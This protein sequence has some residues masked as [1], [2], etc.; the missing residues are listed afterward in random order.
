MDFYGHYSDSTHQGL[1]GH[2]HQLGQ[3]HQE[4]IYT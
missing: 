4:H 1:T 2:I 3:P